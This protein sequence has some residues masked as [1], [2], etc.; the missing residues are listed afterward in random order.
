M[1]DQPGDVRDE[2]GIGAK[3]LHSK[4]KTLHRAVF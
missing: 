4:C 3:Q 1:L 2:D